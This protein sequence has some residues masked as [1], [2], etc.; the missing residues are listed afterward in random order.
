MSILCDSH[1]QC[2]HSHEEVLGDCRTCGDE[3]MELLC[4]C[5]VLTDDLEHSQYFGFFLIMTERSEFHRDNELYKESRYML[6]A[7]MI[8]K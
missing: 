2:V 8:I 6:L 5:V 3:V 7:I 1:I 4:L